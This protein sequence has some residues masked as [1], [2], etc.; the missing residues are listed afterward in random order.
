MGLLKPDT[1][2]E[3]PVVFSDTGRGQFNGRQIPKMRLWVL[4]GRTAVIVTPGPD[5]KGV[6]RTEY[7]VDEG[8]SLAR[9]KK[10]VVSLYPDENPETPPTP[11]VLDI[12]CGCSF[13]AVANV[14]PVDGPHRIVAI[15]SQDWWTPK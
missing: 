5:G 6:T 3:I 8:T 11:L 13:G 15:R 9:D 4:G 1:T 10:V 14:G 7:R 2:P 12:N